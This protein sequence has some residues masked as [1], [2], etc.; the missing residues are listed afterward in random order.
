MF[1]LVAT[2]GYPSTCWALV[3]CCDR[4]DKLWS[5]L[6]LEDHWCELEEFFIF[7]KEQLCCAVLGSRLVNEHC[8]VNFSRLKSLSSVRSENMAALRGVFKWCS[9][10][11]Y[12]L[13]GQHV[14]FARCSVVLP[15]YIMLLL[16][17]ICNCISAQHPMKLCTLCFCF[18]LI[19]SYS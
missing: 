13:T 6:E 3:V 8:C 2:V 1:M 14:V 15:P 11:S 16:C 10:A 5:M 9:E 4:L 12:G 19:I 17:N 7:A 18:A